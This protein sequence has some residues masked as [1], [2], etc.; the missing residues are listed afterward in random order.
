MRLTIGG[1]VRRDSQGAARAIPLFSGSN[2]SIE[3]QR[4]SLF[5]FHVRSLPRF[6]PQQ[7]HYV[8]IHLLGLGRL[9]IMKEPK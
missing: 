4:G 1:A 7:S 9:V 6:H 8:Q 5:L 3:W 2:W